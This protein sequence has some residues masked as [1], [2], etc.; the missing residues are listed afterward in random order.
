M[1]KLAPGLDFELFYWVNSLGGTFGFRDLP[2][3]PPWRSKALSK[4][5]PRTALNGIMLVVY[6][7]VC[8]KRAKKAKHD[9][10]LYGRKHAMTPFPLGWLENHSKTKM[11]AMVSLGQHYSRGRRAYG[12]IKGDLKRRQIDSRPMLG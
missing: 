11:G 5:G 3:A 10:G 6:G 4:L 8:T 9:N 2:F 7:V 12:S 1:P